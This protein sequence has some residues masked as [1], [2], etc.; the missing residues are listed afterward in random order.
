MRT[1]LTAAALVIS[2]ALWISP[3]AARDIYVDNA[4]GD[5]GATGRHARTNSDRTG[6]VRSIAKALRLAETGD[7][8]VLAATGQPYRE[9]VGLVGRRHSGYSF[10]PLVIEG[11]GAILDGSA[12][13]PAD[14]WE[15]Y[16]GAA[17][18]FRPPHLEHQQLFLAGRPVPRVTVSRLAGAPPELKALQWCLHGPYIYFCVEP[19]RLP[20]DY[21]LTYADK[22]VGITLYH[23]RHVAILDLTVQGFQLDGISAF[24]SARRV[25]L[26]GLTCRGN[27]R[28]GI[29]VGG[30]SL[31]EIEA[32][33]LG[34]NGTA[35]LLTLPLSETHVRNSELLGNTAPAWVDQ[36]GRVYVGPKRVEGG[37][38][39]IEPE[40]PPAEPAK[41]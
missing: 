3:A 31:V 25:R 7:R 11:N 30:A 27:G 18:R 12:P 26:A 35:Q 14:A 22:R 5:E 8:I 21:A 24:N 28:A 29:S 19:T 39:K 34:N 4:A 38:E 36:G 6:P 17:F 32:C 9:S 2:T 33:L 10:Q 37:L 40:A 13:V 41:P 16:R 20:E 1:A 15:H 23:V